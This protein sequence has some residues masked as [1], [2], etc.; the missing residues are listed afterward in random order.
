MSKVKIIDTTTENIH[1]FGMCGYKNIKIE[2]YKRKI[3]WVK[4]QFKN[5]M[6][7]KIL[8]SEEDGA[9]GGIEYINA[10]Y[11]YRPVIAKD[12]LLIHCIYIL[13]KKYKTKGYGK[14][15]IDEAIN[16]AKEQK[17]NGVSVVTRHSTF[18]A[19][20][21]LFLKNGFQKVDTLEPDFELLVNKFN[22]SAEDPK[23]NTGIEKELKKYK[24]GLT[25]VTSDQCPYSL[26]VVTEISEVAKSVYKITPKIVEL[27]SFKQAQK[28]PCG[29][30]SFC[31]FY[32][33]KVIADHPIS[34]TR[35]KNIMN[36][37]KK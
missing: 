24:N 29:F 3:N 19:G 5:G 30:G 21:E 9:V 15:L 25:I 6:K 22:K 1:E 18:M 35:F 20:S 8:Y 27:K 13:K 12:Y 17:L 11:S 33:G 2:G 28:I 26:K 14:L 16:D 7:Y 23:F 34:S 32:E 4:K 10:E 36:K 31:I 37:L